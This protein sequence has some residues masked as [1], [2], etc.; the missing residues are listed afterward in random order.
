VADR[1]LPART[2]AL[3]A[4]HVPVADA[5][6]LDL[7]LRK[8]APGEY[9]IATADW[10][11]AGLLTGL[12]PCEWRTA[13][14]D[15]SVLVVD[16]AKSAAPRLRHM[17][18]SALSE[19]DLRVVNVHAERASGWRVLGS[20]EH[21]QLGCAATIRNAC[22]RLWPAPGR[23][24]YTLYSARHQFSSNAKTEHPA[25]EV[26]ALL[27]HVTTKT[28]QRHYGRRGGAW[29]HDDRPGTVL[30]DPAEVALVTNWVRNL[31]AVRK[32]VAEAISETEC[33]FVGSLTPIY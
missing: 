12:R 11:R 31:D 10:L 28:A 3:R 14:L 25:V 24:Y 9:A 1:D 23:R 2:S 29:R 21:A 19:A 30:P 8:Y 20:F 22:C 17:D 7:Y 32:P 5:A 18:L 16:C 15:G 13:R 4:R 6:K 27:G 26:S 33:D